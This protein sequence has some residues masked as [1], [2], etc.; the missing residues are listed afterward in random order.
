MV[1]RLARSPS[2]SGPGIRVVEL[3]M[4]DAAAVGHQHA[5]PAALL[6]TREDLVLDLQVPGEVILPGLQD[7]ARRRDSIT[8]ALQLDGVE[9]RPIRLG[10]SWG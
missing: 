3:H 10:D 5:T 9:V 8:A 6:E 4:L 7:R 1:L 2:T